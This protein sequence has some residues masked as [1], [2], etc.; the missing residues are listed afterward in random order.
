MLKRI[1]GGKTYNT[2]TATLIAAIDSEDSLDWFEHLYQNRFGAYFHHF[3]R[4]VDAIGLSSFVNIEPLTPAEAQ[5]WMEKYHHDSLIETH[6]GEVPE[7]GSGETRFTLRMP[8][9]LKHRIDALAKP[10]KQSVN[11]WIIRCI[12]NCAGVQEKQIKGGQG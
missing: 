4:P 5:E 3:G 12:E 9:S 1:I 11:S 10:N 2:E 6:F 7:A 8:D